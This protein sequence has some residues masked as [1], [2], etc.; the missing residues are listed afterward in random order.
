MPT[1]S[2]E[3]M[4]K[5]CNTH[6]EEILKKKREYRQT[7]K[8]RTKE[9]YKAHKEEIR[10]KSKLFRET[11]KEYEK[12]RHKKYYETHKEEILK[13]GKE[14]RQ[15]NIE[16][17]KERAKNYIKN[18]RKKYNAYQRIYQHK[19]MSL[20]RVREREK[21]RELKKWVVDKLGRKCADCGLVSEYD[22]LYDL[23]HINEE[24]SWARRGRKENHI[25]W[26]MSREL[27]RWQ[28]ENKIPESIQL[29]CSNCH[30]IRHF[31]TNLSKPEI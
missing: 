3:Y 31:K 11:H 29:L 22:C 21:R 6:R 30:R 5:Y 19:R 2:P 25:S 12:Q 14:Y 15:N 10:A 26:F 16:K 17:I 1:N 13:K 24:E 7:H 4:K 23:H 9:Y 27:K 28:K 8:R 20:I 18:N